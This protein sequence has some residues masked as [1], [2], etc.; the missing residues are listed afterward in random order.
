MGD[1]LVVIVPSRGRPFSVPGMANAWKDTGAEAGLVIAVDRDDPTLDAYR[2]ACDSY[3]VE[4]RVG[5]RLRCVGT[6][7]EVTREVLDANRATAIGFMGDDH[8]PRTPGWDQRFMDTLAGGGPGIVY[9]NDLLV[10][11]RFPTAGVLTRDIPDTLG[12]LVPPILTH[13]NFD[14][15]WKNWGDALGRITYLDDVIIEHMHPAAGKAR[16]DKG[17]LSVNND[18]MVRVDGEAYTLYMAGGFESDVAKLK[19]LL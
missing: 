3:G 7:N 11:D 4:Y 16:L 14:V 6:L 2:A 18:E 13:L 17:Y 15:I 12:Y 19:A 9:G 8:R 1:G 10:G 5:E